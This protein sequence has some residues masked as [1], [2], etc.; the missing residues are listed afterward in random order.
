MEIVRA[1]PNIELQLQ[2]QMLQFP[3]LLKDREIWSKLELY[4]LFVSH[5]PYV[6]NPA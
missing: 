5:D 6:L 2:L 1:N 4:T 3:I